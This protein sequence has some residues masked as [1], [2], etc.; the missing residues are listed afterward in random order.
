MVGR[1]GRQVGELDVPMTAADPLSGGHARSV[2][3]ECGRSLARRGEVPAPKAERQAVAVVRS[4]NLQLRSSL[5]VSYIEFLYNIYHKLKAAGGLLTSRWLPSRVRCL[6]LPDAATG[7]LSF[8]Y[9]SR[10][11]RVLV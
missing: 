8:I 7:A 11:N 10:I 6:L 4:F 5:S 3:A 2:R 1:P 9:C